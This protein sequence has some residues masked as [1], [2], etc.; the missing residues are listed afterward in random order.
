M[1]R[2]LESQ[3]LGKQETIRLMVLSVL[4]GEHIALIGPPGP[5]KSAQESTFAKSISSTY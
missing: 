1:A 4:A 3:F 5:A 2:A